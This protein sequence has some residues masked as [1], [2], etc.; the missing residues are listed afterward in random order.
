MAHISL[1]PK[2]TKTIHKMRKNIIMAPAA[3]LSLAGFSPEAFAAEETTSFDFSL[4]FDYFTSLQ[5]SS[6]K[7]GSEVYQA[8]EFGSDYAD[9]YAGTEITSVNITA[10]TYK[11]TQTNT[12]KNITIFL[13]DDLESEPFYTQSGKLG[14]EGA[15]MYKIDLDTSHT[16]EAGKG[17]VIGYYFRLTSEDVNY[18]SVDGFYH[19]NP[20]GGWIGNK[21][22]DGEVKW[23]NI[24]QTYGNLC[25]G[26]TIKGDNL[27]QNG[28][29]VLSL[30]G[31]EF[32]EPG[33]NFPFT[34]YFQNTASNDVTSLEVKYTVGN[35][36]PSVQTVT[37]SEP[38][39]YN[40]RK[41][42]RYTNL[43]SSA[44][45]VD[46]PVVFE[47]TK[48]NGQPNTSVDKSRVSFLNC[49]NAADGFRRVHLMEEGTGTWCQWCP[50][51]IVMM[52]RIKEKYPEDY[53]LVAVHF[54]DQMTVPTTAPVCNLFTGYPTALIDRSTALYPQNANFN[55]VFDQFTAYYAAI[56]AVTGVTTLKGV[57]TEEGNLKVTTGLEFAL[58]ME[59]A[60]RYRLS[61]YLTEDGVG[62]YTQD[63]SQY[64]GGAAGSMGG[65]EDKGLTVSMLFDDVARLLEGELTGIEGS[66]PTSVEKGKEYLYEAELPLN[67]VTKDKVNLVAFVVDNADG[68]VVNAKAVE[69]DLTDSGISAPVESPAYKLTLLP[70]AIAIEG[71]FAKAEIHSISGEKVAS[72]N[73]PALLPLPSGLYIATVDG[74]PVKVLVK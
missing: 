9:Q 54:N 26:C 41:G 39:A 70:G 33:K 28:V 25:I 22:G 65:W 56:P 29:A 13:A 74:H 59:T 61:Y 58:D 51:G 24:S 40:Q 73:A 63:N 14:E 6:Y 64:S 42:L 2:P 69:V 31:Q 49:F 43:K 57:K 35:D 44:P 19:E 50:A 53:A 48:V 17:I 52:E 5:N 68:S 23:S 30:D 67:R 36:E 4:A 10:G 7:R 8:F 12:V 72:L 32:A 3:L 46:I 47:V 15:T 71:S 37:L 34:V 38:L 21:V 60:A 18:I 11:D 1:K 66:V 45:G 62:P 55:S 27:P 16:I 20:A